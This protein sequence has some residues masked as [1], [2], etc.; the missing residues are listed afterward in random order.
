MDEIFNLLLWDLWHIGAFGEPV[1]GAQGV[2]SVLN[3]GYWEIAA[4]KQLVHHTVLMTE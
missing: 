2:D 3:G 1:G 4:E